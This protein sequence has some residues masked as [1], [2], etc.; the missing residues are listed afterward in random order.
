MQDAPP[1]THCQS[2]LLDPARA[3]ALATT[4][5]LS[6]PIEAGDDLPPFFHQVF[7]ESEDLTSF[8]RFLL[9]ILVRWSP[10]MRKKKYLKLKGKSQ[11]ILEV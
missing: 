6:R 3:A 11:V 4:L 9:Y 10:G 5:G 7:H 8:T 1:E 2:D